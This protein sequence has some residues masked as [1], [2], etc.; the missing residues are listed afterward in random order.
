[1]LIGITIATGIVHLVSVGIG[2]VIGNALPD[3]AIQAVSG[4]AFIGFAL[5]TLRGDDLDE[6]DRQKIDQSAD[7]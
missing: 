3:R 5:W 2:A 6:N 7:R 1:M 4:V